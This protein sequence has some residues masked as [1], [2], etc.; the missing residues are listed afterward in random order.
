MISQLREHLENQEVHSSD[1]PA[2]QTSQNRNQQP[3]M[4]TI[5]VKIIVPGGREMSVF[6]SPSNPV[7]T[8]KP[9]VKSKIDDLPK[10]VKFVFGG[11][12]LDDWSLLAESGVQDG[13]VLKLVDGKRWEAERRLLR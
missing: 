9:K 5:I 10:D 6:A 4:I 8:L 12:L 7:W 11:S 1:D 13:S 2:I 3:N